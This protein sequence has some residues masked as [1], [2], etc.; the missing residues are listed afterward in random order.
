MSFGELA[1]V[2][3]VKQRGKEFGHPLTEPVGGCDLEGPGGGVCFLIWR[4]AL[5]SE[6][7]VGGAS[8]AGLM[9]KDVFVAVFTPNRQNYVKTPTNINRIF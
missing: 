6:E 4:E 8:G 5:S 9:D 2:E 3:R 1:V 7:P